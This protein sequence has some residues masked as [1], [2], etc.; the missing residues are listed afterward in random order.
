M[1]VVAI[2]NL[3]QFLGVIL[4][5]VAAVALA[6]FLVWCVVGAILWFV[7][8]SSHETID[9]PATEPEWFDRMHGEP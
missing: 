2:L 7:A 4:A 1:N 9:Q 3:A 6:A 8:P 5:L